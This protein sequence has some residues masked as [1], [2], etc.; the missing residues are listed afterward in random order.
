M[1]AQERKNLASPSLA[2]RELFLDESGGDRDAGDASKRYDET[3]AEALTSSSH[4]PQGIAQ[5]ADPTGGQEKIVWH[6]KQDAGNFTNNTSRSFSVRFP[7]EFLSSS[8]SLT[9]LRTD[10]TFRS[11]QGNWF[12]F[13]TPLA[14]K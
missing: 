12:F 11:G 14:G 1:S 5:V 7:T 10:F 13:A 6:L 2:V 3:M 9:R 8:H 4:M